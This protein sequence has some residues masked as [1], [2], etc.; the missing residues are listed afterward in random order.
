MTKHL[1][2]I[3]GWTYSV[4]PWSQTLIELSNLGIETT[5]L[6]VPGLTSPSDEVWTIDR[7][8]QWLDTQ[9]EGAQTPLVLG[10]SNGGRI[11]MHYLQ[12]YP[13]RFAKLIL[14]A[15]AGAETQAAR[16]SMKRRLF[17]YASKLLAPLKH[18]PLA[19]KVVYRLL[20]SDYGAAPSNMQQTLKNMLASDRNFAPS[21]I[22]VPTSLVYG[23]ADTTT[24]P[25]VGEK[26][27]QAIT[28]SSIKLIDD[29]GHAPYKT[30]PKQ[31]A[32]EI[33]TQLEEQ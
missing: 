10:H 15:S 25:A 23:K 27:H 12:K 29:W 7:Y 3:H 13:N 8:V 33:A 14:L 22:T 18:I 26:L 28:G 19:K 11:A 21:F 9:L 32:T 30:H 17:K 20:G 24:P 4:E 16:L 31:L 6:R 5:M 1:Y 2:I